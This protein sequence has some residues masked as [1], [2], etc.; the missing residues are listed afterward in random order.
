MIVENAHLYFS[1]DFFPLQKKFF[2]FGC[3][4]AVAV[5]IT[6]SLILSLKS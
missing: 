2:L 5:I 6:L 1:F 4:I 3:L